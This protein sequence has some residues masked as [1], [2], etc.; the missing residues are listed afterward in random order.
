MSV[1][2]TLF[3]RKIYLQKI[4]DFTFVACENLKSIIMKD[5]RYFDFVLKEKT[6]AGYV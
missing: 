5:N 2:F 1:S 4:E 3:L 6:E